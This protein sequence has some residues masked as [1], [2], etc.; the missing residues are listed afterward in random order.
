MSNIFATFAP[1]FG[2]TLQNRLQRYEKKMEN[3]NKSV[4]KHQSYWV[5]LFAVL[6][7]GTVN[8]KVN[9]YI[10]AYAQ[11][12]EW[13]FFPS[14][15]SKYKTSFGAAGGV[16]FLYEL[17]AGGKYSPTRFLFDVGVGAQGGMT[18]YIQSAAFE[19]SLKD[20]TDLNG[21]PFDYVY[22]FE[23]RKD[24]Y[25][26]V[27]VQVPI[28]IGLQHNSFYML[29]GAKV[30]ANLF[31]KAYTSA[32]LSTYG[33]YELFPDMTPEKLDY[34]FFDNV[35]LKANANAS[36]SNLHIDASLEIGGRLGY[37]S[38]D[39]GFDVPKSKV[40]Y[41]LAGFVDYGVTDIH[42]QRSLE[43]YTPAE[44]YDIDK[45]SPNYIY[46]TT[47]MIDNLTV[48]DI[49]ATTNFASKVTNFVVGLK[50]TVLFQ[51]P[52]DKKCVLCHDSYRSSA[53]SYTGNRGRMKYEE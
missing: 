16:G 4:K 48:N 53:R 34:Q 25:L 43:G 17:K 28:M 46:Q 52:E 35:P 2:C 49:M 15:D 11:V 29:V 50:F 33:H 44:K 47:T 27:A 18:N 19:I 22:R 37:H 30:N 38:N 20:Q 39:V 12:G 7:C 40:E 5:L 51:L 9:N 36:L 8:A 32:V 6:I 45:E 1:H 3:T 13:S 14:S 31:K 41:R 42:T 26:N 10:G 24:Q 21:D 23:D